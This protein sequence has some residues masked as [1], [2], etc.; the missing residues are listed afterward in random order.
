AWNEIAA[1]VPIVFFMVWIGVHPNTFLEK[2][3]PSV[4]HLLTM[5]NGGAEARTPVLARRVAGSSLL[6]ARD[7]SPEPHIT[8]HQ[9]P[10][11]SKSTGGAR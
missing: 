11:T 1:L 6:V 5:V 10:A 7:S 9:Q 4:K 3:E 8:S 2:M